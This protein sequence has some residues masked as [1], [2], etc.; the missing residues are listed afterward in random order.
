MATIRRESNRIST[1]A[2]NPNPRQVRPPCHDVHALMNAL[3]A[4]SHRGRGPAARTAE[5]W[6]VSPS[7][8][9]APRQPKR[10][11]GDEWALSCEQTRGRKSCPPDFLEAPGDQP[12][13]S[14]RDLSVTAC[15]K[16]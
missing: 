7:A 15:P 3:I 8:A 12:D 2:G 13:R 11:T 9:M 10:Q 1:H 5:L 14:N 6:V 16:A 4:P